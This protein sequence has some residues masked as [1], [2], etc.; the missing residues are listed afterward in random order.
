MS[1]TGPMVLRLFMYLPIHLIQTLQMHVYD[2]VSD[3]LLTIFNHP[4][5]FHVWWEPEFLPPHF[6]LS[7]DL[8]QSSFY[9]QMS[10]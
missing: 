10:H 5:H 3:D 4:I 9:I 2:T 1:D 8:G 6:V 7:E